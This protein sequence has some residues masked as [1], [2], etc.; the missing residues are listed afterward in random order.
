MLTGTDA[1]LLWKFGYNFGFKG[2]RS[3]ERF[4]KRLA[5]RASTSRRSLHLDHQQLQPAL[6]GLLGRRGRPA[7]NIIDEPTRSTA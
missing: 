1:R 7:Q 5:K 4:K 3:V 2:M 6:P